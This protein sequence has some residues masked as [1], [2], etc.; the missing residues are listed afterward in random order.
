MGDEVVAAF[1][2]LD[3]NGDGLVVLS[4][5]RRMLMDAGASLTEEEFNDGVDDLFAG[6]NGEIDLKLFAETFMAENGSECNEESEALVPARVDQVKRSG[7]VAGDV[8]C[9]GGLQRAAR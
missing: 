7:V 5:L 8:G 6:S 3:K 2:A 9:L 1:K 4:D